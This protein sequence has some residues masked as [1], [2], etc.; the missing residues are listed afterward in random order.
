MMS[1]TR[2]I[3]FC[4]K[5]LKRTSVPCETE[6]LEIWQ[7][8]LLF[9]HFGHLPNDPSPQRGILLY[10]PS[11]VHADEETVVF[12]DMLSVF[13]RISI[14]TP[15]ER[16]EFPPLLFIRFEEQVAPLLLS[17]DYSDT[18]AVRSWFNNFS[19]I[20][21]AF[22]DL[23]GWEWSGLYAVDSMRKRT[24]GSIRGFGSAADVTVMSNVPHESF[25]YLAHRAGCFC[26]SRDSY[27]VLNRLFTSYMESVFG[28]VVS[29]GTGGQTVVHSAEIQASLQKCY[30]Q[31]IVGFGSRGYARLFLDIALVCSC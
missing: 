6:L 16:E 22:H 14:P 26:L 17:A 23:N 21:N 10:F 1:I 24:L 27:G 5:V 20:A 19:C 30:N 28:L 3:L 11:S 18:E 4:E 29:V 31:H 9:A 7:D 8:L 13:F 25:I 2:R 15:L 12:E